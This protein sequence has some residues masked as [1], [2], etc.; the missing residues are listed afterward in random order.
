M[1]DNHYHLVV[2]TPEANVSKGMRQLDGVYAQACNR[3]H[4][5]VG[6]LFQG[7]YKA[8]LEDS[9]PNLLELARVE[10]RILWSESPGH[11]PPEK[12]SVGS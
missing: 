1:M 12:G 3:R 7:R 2:E 10:R 9:E 6:H 4:R 11:R 8:I 5:Q